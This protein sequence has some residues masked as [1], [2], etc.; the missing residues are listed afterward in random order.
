MNGFKLLE[1]KDV[2]PDLESL[3]ERGWDCGHRVGI[4]LFEPHYNML[5]DGCTD[6]SGYPVSGKSE[7]LLELLFN[8]T[9]LYGWKHLLF[10]PDMG[11]SI[12]VMAKLIHKHTG[13][14]FLKKYQNYITI[15]EA[16]H[17]C[18]FLIEHFKII[19]KTDS[20]AKVTPVQFWEFAVKVKNEQ[21]LNSMVIDSWKDM[22]HEYGKH[23]GSYATYLS[24]I[25]PIRNDI[26]EKNKIHSHIIIHP[27]NPIVS[28]DRKIYP[29]NSFDMEGG[30][31]WA[32]SGKC[33]IV[34]HRTDF[35]SNATDVYFRKIKP[36][37]V[38][39][40]TNTPITLYFDVVKSRYYYM[41][42]MGN[43]IYSSGEKR[44]EMKITPNQNIFNA[45]SRIEP[46]KEVDNSDN[47]PF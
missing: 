30:A 41:D 27:K 7:L 12:E 9:A 24:E 1:F 31:Q 10:V 4:P 32:N 13:K 8:M 29:P 22:N 23:G 14:T 42:D 25:L 36:E 28:K 19:H 46:I 2:Q 43:K 18:T 45:D 38:G 16:F 15:G 11:K 33:I 39:K 40:N 35:D 47:A 17:A 26:C 34:V 6:W 37:S 3:H 44:P 20:K 5:D 21:G